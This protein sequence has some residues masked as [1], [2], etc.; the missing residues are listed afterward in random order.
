MVK[1]IHVAHILVKDEAQAKSLTQELNSGG[2][3]EKLAKKFST[4]PSS[5]N[6]GDLGW[7]GRNKMVP[8]FDK[9][10]F[11]GKKGEIVGPVKS[12]FGYHIIKVIDRK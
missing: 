7:F 8:E 3:F 12:Q 5:K 9:A 6:G 1:K 2:D 11:D 4:C 10:A